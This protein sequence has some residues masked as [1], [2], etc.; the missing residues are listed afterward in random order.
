MANI[1]QGAQVRMVVVADEAA[2][3]ALTSESVQNGDT[4]KQADTNIMYYVK[5]ETKLGTADAADAFEVYRA[6]MAAHADSAD[7]ATNAAAAPWT[8]ITGKPEEYTPAAHNQ[9]SATVNNLTGY[10]K[11]QTVADLTEQDTLNVALGKLEKKADEAAAAAADYDAIPST[12]IAAIIA[13]TYG[14]S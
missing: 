6:G 3:L 8:G 2:R 13:G 9:G 5:D 1:P 14:Q 12:D 4:V 7:N 11:A 10:S